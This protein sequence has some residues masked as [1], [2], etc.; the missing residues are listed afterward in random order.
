MGSKPGSGRSPRGKPGKPLQYSC[1]ENSMDSGPGGL[2][3]YGCRV[4]HD[5]SNLVHT[6]IRTNN[7]KQ[8]LACKYKF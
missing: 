5:C 1:L 2:S 3:S 8:M 4:G 7:S 6:D